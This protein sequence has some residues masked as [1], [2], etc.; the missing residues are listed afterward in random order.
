[1]DINDNE[2]ESNNLER[3]DIE[4]LHNDTYH[5]EEDKSVDIPQ[6]LLEKGLTLSNSNKAL[7]DDATALMGT[8]GATLFTT[9]Y[10]L[11]ALFIVGEDVLEDCI[12]AMKVFFK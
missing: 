8:K 1:M 7:E 3:E 4:M 12:R 5:I 2:E 6:E 11:K 9:R 10:T